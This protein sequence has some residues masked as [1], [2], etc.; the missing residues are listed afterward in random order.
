MFLP[1]WRTMAHKHWDVNLPLKKCWPSLFKKRG[2]KIEY[3]NYLAKIISLL[4]C[5]VTTRPKASGTCLVGAAVGMMTWRWH[6]LHWMRKSRDWRVNY[7]LVNVY[8][9]GCMDPSFFWKVNQLFQWSFPRAMMLNW[10]TVAFAKNQLFHP[11]MAYGWQ[12]LTYASRAKMGTSGRDLINSLPQVV[13]PS[14]TVCSS[15]P[16]M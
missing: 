14:S 2:N 12:W 5:L 15:T 8:S 10:Q 16:P 13:P 11:N 3:W 9:Y 1:K 4:V 7:P 6:F